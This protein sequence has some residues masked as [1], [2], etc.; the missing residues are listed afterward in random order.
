MKLS[1]PGGLTGL[2]V[3]VYWVA[4]RLQELDS[5]IQGTFY[6]CLITCVLHS[7]T[8]GGEQCKL[9]RSSNDL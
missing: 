5:C 7:T 9:S 3:W 4:K 2:K 6:L 1:F 8:S